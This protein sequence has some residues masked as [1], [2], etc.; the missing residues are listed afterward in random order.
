[1]TWNFVMKL[2]YF[3][4][5]FCILNLDG[6]IFFTEWRFYHNNANSYI[7]YMVNDELILLYISNKMIFLA[8]NYSCVYC[9]YVFIPYLR[10]AKLCTFVGYYLLFTYSAAWRIP[11][12]TRRCPLGGFNPYGY[13]CVTATKFLAISHVTRLLNDP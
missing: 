7:F 3:I 1:M 12:G 13:R 5:I 10:N 8:T 2:I 11:E 9:R 4:R 6:C